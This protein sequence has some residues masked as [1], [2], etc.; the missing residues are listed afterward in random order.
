MSSESSISYRNL[1][2]MIMYN[3][4]I[5]NKLTESKN[6][7]ENY[8][9]LLDF[10]ADILC[11]CIR[12]MLD[13]GLLNKF[14]SHLIETDRP[15]GS[16]DI[17]QQAKKG[18]LGKA[19]LACKVNQ[20]DINTHCNM[21]I[22]AAINRLLILNR[23]YKNHE[24]QNKNIRRLRYFKDLLYDVSDITSIRGIRLLS[25]LELPQKYRQVYSI[26]LVILKN[27][28]VSS[29]S[30]RENLLDIKDKSKIYEI[31]Q[32]FVAS[33]Y[34]KKLQ[35]KGLE[36]TSQ[37]GIEWKSMWDNQ[38]ST[39]LR[40]DCIIKDKINKRI[41]IIDTKWYNSE[42]DKSGENLKIGINNSEI[43]KSVLYG[44]A[45][46]ESKDYNDYEICQIVLMA[47]NIKTRE[48]QWAFHRNICEQSKTF[49]I[50]V[51]HHSMDKSFQ[52]IENDLLNIANV[53]LTEDLQKKPDIHQPKNGV[54]SAKSA[55]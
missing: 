12:D 1:F 16:I 11:G 48:I 22:K 7:S 49:T 47:K 2:Y 36:V 28:L 53:F 44:M 34:K 25:T 31:Y 14:N 4:N 13:N 35:N 50:Q 52:D 43:G 19:N 42:A 55:F 30:G 29:Q 21:I 10:Q 15:R 23:L 3:Q 39:N 54:Y 24:I 38:I 37:E 5:Y 9:Q 41:L 46:K 32:N 6:Q 17:Q 45:F 40:P 26:Q 18:L 33:F 8:M 27:F 20:V 51:I